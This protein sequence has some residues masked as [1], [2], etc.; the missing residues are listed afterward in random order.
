MEYTI[1]QVL[2]TLPESIA[3]KK[4]S[5]NLFEEEYK[6]KLDAT[7]NRWV[8]MDVVDI[9]GLDRKRPEYINAV[10]KFYHRKKAWTVKHG[11]DYEFQN[12]RTES[13]FIMFGKRVING[14]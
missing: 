3:P 14:I 5:V 10:G 12:I 7:P 2:D 11:P 8:A 13:Q 1:G 6:D 4:A 9:T